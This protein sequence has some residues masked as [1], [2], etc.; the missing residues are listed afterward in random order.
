MVVLCLVPLGSLILLAS[1]FGGM[2]FH[3]GMVIY[4]WVAIVAVVGGLAIGAS[5]LWAIK[6]TELDA[7]TRR[8]ATWLAW[9]TILGPLI[10][11]FWCLWA[12]STVIHALFVE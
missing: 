3:F 5:L 11:S 9:A 4:V 10:M 12:V 2:L 7:D 6:R 1:A 8:H